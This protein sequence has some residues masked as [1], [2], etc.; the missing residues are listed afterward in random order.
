MSIT[1]FKSK[2]QKQKMC[3]ISLVV[4]NINFYFKNR[5]TEIFPVYNQRTT[6]QKIMVNKYTA[7]I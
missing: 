5:N 3:Y 4:E 2:K 7:V 6:G 1:L